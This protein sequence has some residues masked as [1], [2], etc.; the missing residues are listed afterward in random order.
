LFFSGLD[1]RTHLNSQ[2]DFA[3]RYQTEKPEF[4]P[5]FSAMERIRL[6]SEHRPQNVDI[7]LGSGTKLA[8]DLR[9]VIGEVLRWLSDQHGHH[10]R[11]EG[12]G[13]KAT[14]DVLVILVALVMLFHPYVEGAG[15]ERSETVFRVYDKFVR[16]F[17]RYVKSIY[18]NE[19]DLRFQE[20][21]KTM[22]RVKYF[23][24]RLDKG[25]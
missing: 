16:M 11:S 20:G 21:M 13:A 23:K 17:H 7:I 6:A 19:A 24:E 10:G 22:A 15:L 5:L 12:E 3:R 8:V 18:P 25:A 1:F 14:D 9:H 4:S 2:V